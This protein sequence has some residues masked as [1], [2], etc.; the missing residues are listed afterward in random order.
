MLTGRLCAHMVPTY[1]EALWASGGIH[2]LGERAEVVV[3]Q[4][5][6][7]VERH[8]CGDLL[9]HHEPPR[10]RARGRRD[11]TVSRP[12]AARRALGPTTSKLREAGDGRAS[13]P[14]PS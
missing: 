7:H 4:P 5:R 10:D 12:D 8:R 2:A 13:I 6:V 9:N 1:R 3:E 14:R 11:G